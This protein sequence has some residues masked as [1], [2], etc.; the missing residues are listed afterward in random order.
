VS[1]KRKLLDSVIFG[2]GATAGARLFDEIKDELVG[3]DEP[4]QAPKKEEE[5]P[6]QKTKREAKEAKKAAEAR[7]KAAAADEAAIDA[8]LAALKKR[9]KS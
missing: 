6:A 3:E 9:I 2:V 8:E 4:D 5:T 7:R 1:I